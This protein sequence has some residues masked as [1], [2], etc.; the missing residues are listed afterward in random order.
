MFI[1]KRSHSKLFSI[2]VYKMNNQLLVGLLIVCVLIFLMVGKKMKLPKQVEKYSGFIMVGV[3]ILLFFC[4]SKK[5]I[6]EGLKQDVVDSLTQ[7]VADSINN[8]LAPHVDTVEEDETGTGD[9]P[10]DMDPE[11]PDMGK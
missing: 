7:G 2:V 8:I 11:A 4:M 3:L 9:S 10:A 5:R 6:V 1:I